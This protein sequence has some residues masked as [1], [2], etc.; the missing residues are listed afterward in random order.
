MELWCIL[1]GHSSWTLLKLLFGNIWE[2]NAKY[3]CVVLHYGS[4]LTFWPHRPH[5][6]VVLRPPSPHGLLALIP[7]RDDLYHSSICT[8]H[9]LDC[10]LLDWFTIVFQFGMA[11]LGSRCFPSCSGG[12]QK[13]SGLI[14]PPHPLSPSFSGGLSQGQ[15][16]RVVCLPRI[17]LEISDGQLWGAPV[18]LG[19]PDLIW[20]FSDVPGCL[21][22]PVV[23]DTHTSVS[24]CHR[25]Q[26]MTWT[27][28][29]WSSSRMYWKT[30]SLLGVPLLVDV[31][32]VT[33]PQMFSLSSSSGPAHTYLLSQVL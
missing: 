4:H 22:A 31:L 8:S 18:A 15:E 21:W 7:S 29:D 25:T 32:S 28:S 1:I 33:P 14:Y 3:P 23:S 2:P 24:L 12:V 11:P 26:H 5:V 20:G 17:E 30:T 10:F 19:Y 27:S 6:S 16:F 9:T 13:N